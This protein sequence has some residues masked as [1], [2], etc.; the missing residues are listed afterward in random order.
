MTRARISLELLVYADGSKLGTL[1][2]G[3]G[4]MIWKR[5]ARKPQRIRWSKF[6]DLMDELRT[7]VR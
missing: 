2:L 5:G 4:S 6:A 1:T 3:A 7:G